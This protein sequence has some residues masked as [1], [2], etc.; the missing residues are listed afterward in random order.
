MTHM[1]LYRSASVLQMGR[2]LYDTM[3][4]GQEIQK[5]SVGLVDQNSEPI[6]SLLDEHWST[7]VVIELER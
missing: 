5:I 7:N 3:W 4:D 6:T 1:Y 2:C